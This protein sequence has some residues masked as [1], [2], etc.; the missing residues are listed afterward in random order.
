MKIIST[1]TAPAAIGPYSQG[2][3]TNGFF[4]FSGQIAL[5]TEGTFIESNT[6]E[7]TKQV[8]KNI[9]SLLNSQNLTTK[10]VIKTTIF[11][12]N[13]EDFQKVNELYAKFFE[14][15]KPARSTI[16]VS[17]LPKNAKIEIEVIATK[18][19]PIFS[20]SEKTISP[21]TFQPKAEAHNSPN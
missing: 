9:K 15:H 10:N 12:K 20:S 17:N 18:P 1:K 5:T 6:E 4:F 11:L 21:Q 14:P 8:L 13:I 7:Q 16:E 2:I 3:E 19:N